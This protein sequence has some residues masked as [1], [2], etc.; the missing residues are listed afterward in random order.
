MISGDRHRQY[1]HASPQHAG[2]KEARVNTLKSKDGT[3][4]VFDEQGDCP[5]LILVDGAMCTRSS[6]S[7]P[8]F[9]KLL[10]QHFTVYS[11]D[12]RGRGSSGVTK[13]S[14]VERERED[15]D[16]LIDEA[17]GSDR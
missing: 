12:R 14:A 9:A 7:K 3:T 4:I 15:V 10:A 13:P 6:G 17:G 1:G 5:A 11:Y 2:L 8:E 16:A